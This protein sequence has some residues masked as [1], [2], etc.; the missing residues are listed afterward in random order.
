NVTIVDSDGVDLTDKVR[1]ADKQKANPQMTQ[2]QRDFQRDI[3][4]QLGKDLTA[5]LE[6]ALGPNKAVVHV[7]T[8]LNWDQV[9]QDSEFFVPPS[10]VPD[11]RPNVVR[12]EQAISEKFAGPP[13]ALPAGIPG[14][15]SNV[16][17]G[18]Q[19]AANLGIPG[20][21]IAY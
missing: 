12:S 9:T 14:T 6:K 3:E 15:T 18:A 8:T 4:T 10:T 1:Q 13:A 11:A 21:P 5:V 20:A 2:Q 7:N 19:A 16:G 17:A